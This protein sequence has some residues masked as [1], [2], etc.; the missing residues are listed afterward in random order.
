MA[1]VDEGKVVIAVGQGERAS[2]MYGI[3]TANIWSVCACE[4]VLVLIGRM[5]DWLEM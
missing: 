2:L 1:N 3:E 4:N 5:G